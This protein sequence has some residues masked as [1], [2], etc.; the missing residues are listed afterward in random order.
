MFRWAGALIQ[1]AQRELAEHTLTAVLAAL[2]AF[3]AVPSFV[4]CV[5]QH[6]AELLAILSSVFE[7]YA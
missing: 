2:R 3:A 4:A 5:N 6:R 1:L 7:G